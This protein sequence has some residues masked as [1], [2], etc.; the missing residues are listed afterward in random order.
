MVTMFYGSAAKD[1]ELHGVLSAKLTNT[2]E[3]YQVPPV[4]F[5]GCTFNYDSGRCEWRV[6]DQDIVPKTLYILNLDTRGLGGMFEWRNTVIATEY[7]VLGGAPYR[8]EY[9]GRRRFLGCHAKVTA[10]VDSKTGAQRVCVR[11]EAPTD[12][13]PDYYSAIMSRTE[14]PLYWWQPMPGVR[15]FFSRL[16]WR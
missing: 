14:R 5:S 10:R 13:M 2:K 1:T 9:I 12:L 11:A 6:T 15:G 8:G 7:D 4:D 16:S 3:G